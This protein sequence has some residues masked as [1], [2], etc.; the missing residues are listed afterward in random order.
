MKT[1]K[2]KDAVSKDSQVQQGIA[3]YFSLKD[4]SQ[5]VLTS[6]VSNLTVNLFNSCIRGCNL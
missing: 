5:F 6:F 4:Y 1:G 3:S 2:G